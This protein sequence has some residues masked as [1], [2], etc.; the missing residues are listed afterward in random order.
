MQLAYD[1]HT[2]SLFVNFFSFFFLFFL[3]VICCKIG[4]FNLIIDYVGIFI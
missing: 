3:Y 2:C 4:I 1:K